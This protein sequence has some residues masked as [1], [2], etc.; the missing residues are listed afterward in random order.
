MSYTKDDDKPEPTNKKEEEIRTGETKAEETK[1]HEQFWS[2]NAVPHSLRTEQAVPEKQRLV[3]ILEEAGRNLVREFPDV[4]IGDINGPFKTEKVADGYICK[5]ERKGTS[6]EP[7]KI[8]LA[9]GD[10]EIFDKLRTRKARPSNIGE[11][12]L[13]AQ[14][15]SI[16]QMTHVAP[17]DAMLQLL[18]DSLGLSLPTDITKWISQEYDVGLQRAEYITA[19]V[20]GELGS[21]AEEFLKSMD[22]EATDS[23]IQKYRQALETV[24]AKHLAR[25]LDREYLEDVVYKTHLFISADVVPQAEAT[26]ID[27]RKRRWSIR[28]KK[29]PQTRKQVQHINLKEPTRYFVPRGEEEQQLEEVAGYVSRFLEKNKDIFPILMMNTFEEAQYHQETFR[30]RYETAI[31]PISSAPLVL[32]RRSR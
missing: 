28:R 6:M 16:F 15:R 9:Y 30:G 7:Q 13:A 32:G 17:E 23:N 26:N 27:N 4:I 24:T 21:L 20:C 1:T 22:L 19:D 29:E 2:V 12:R 14:R 31:V 18:F 3:A 10:Y 5:V 25:Q 11:L 8:I